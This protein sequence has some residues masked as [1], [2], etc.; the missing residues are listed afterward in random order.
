MILNSL[1]IEIGPG[2][3]VGIVGRTGSGKSTI[4]M[5]LTRIVE[6]FAGS[7]QIDGVDISHIPLHR[8]R[9][10]LTVIQ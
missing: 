7:I 3:K 5:A 10:N 9:D 1:S 4:G 6:V 8:L 2:M